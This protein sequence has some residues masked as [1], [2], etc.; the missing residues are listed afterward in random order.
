[1]HS[2]SV[3][4]E[5]RL[6]CGSPSDHQSPN[7]VCT[8]PRL[9]RSPSSSFLA[10]RLLFVPRVSTMMST[11]CCSDHYGAVCPHKPR[12]LPWLRRRGDRWRNRVVHLYHRLQ[13]RSLDLC[14]RVSTPVTRGKVSCQNLVSRR[15]CLCP[16]RAIRWSSCACSNRLTGRSHGIIRI[17]WRVGGLR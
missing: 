8:R 10:D 11:R 15:S 9:R 5:N 14:S 1:M 17:S 16:A 12:R 3:S 2:A 6:S 4:E 13:L 7:L